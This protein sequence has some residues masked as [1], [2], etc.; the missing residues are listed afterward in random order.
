[1]AKKHPTPTPAQCIADML[2]R[3]VRLRQIVEGCERHGSD[4]SIGHLSRVKS[5]ERDCSQ[6]L[7]N[8]LLAMRAE[9]VK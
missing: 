6:T 9:V 4:V 2:S 7:H 3:K 5:G 1:M 8:A